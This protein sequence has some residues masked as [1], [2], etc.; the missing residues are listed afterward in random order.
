MGRPNKKW[1]SIFYRGRELGAQTHTIGSIVHTG[2]GGYTFGSL[3]NSILTLEGPTQGP[4]T[5]RGIYLDGGRRGG[6]QIDGEWGNP[7][8][9]EGSYIDRGVNPIP[10]SPDADFHSIYT[11]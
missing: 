6:T 7:L 4:L 2:G 9:D 11:F 8:S 3:C 10:C 5:G 1:R